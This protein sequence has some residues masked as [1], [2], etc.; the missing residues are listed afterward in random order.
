M[1]QSDSYDAAKHVKPVQCPACNRS[2]P[3]LPGMVCASC[4]R[5]LRDMRKEAWCWKRRKN[6][7][8]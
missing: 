5:K 6:A 2:L 3:Q 7:L 4:L 8:P 1:K